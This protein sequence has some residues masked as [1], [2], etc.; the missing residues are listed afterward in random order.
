[1]YA[2]RLFYVSSFGRAD[3][4]V[5][6]TLH[7]DFK[8]WIAGFMSVTIKRIPGMAFDDAMKARDRILDT[9]HKLID[10]FMAENPEESERAQTTIIGRLVYG[11]DK[12]NNRM[13][14]R[15]EMKD[16]VLA[17]ILS[18]HDTTC[19]SISTL[20]YHLS[21]NPEAME[22][23]AEEVSALSEPLNSYELKNA[24]VLNACLHESWRTDPPVIGSFRK[25]AKEI[26][27]KG[28]SFDVGQVFNYSILM[29][30]M[31][32][33]CTRIM[34]SSTW[35]DSYPKTIHCI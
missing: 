9:V 27:H 35:D 34:I 13:L 10:E 3:E 14:T 1:M 5:I 23:L 16:N 22:A 2:L 20:L 17:M 26:G 8:L 21:Q 33:V 19:A 31:M 32:K 18:G 12:D 15:D 4:D 7:D 30:T 24:S 11:K 29:A 25:A 28:Y 6:A